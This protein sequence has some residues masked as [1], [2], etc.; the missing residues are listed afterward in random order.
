[1]TMLSVCACGQTKVLSVNRFCPR[2]FD[3]VKI[4][5]FLAG[6]DQLCRN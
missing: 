5:Q 1:M 3:N 2:K 6:Q 4:I